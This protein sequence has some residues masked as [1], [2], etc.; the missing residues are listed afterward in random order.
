MSLYVIITLLEV[1][2]ITV[3]DQMIN[4]QAILLKDFNLSNFNGR[5]FR[6]SLRINMNIIHKAIRTD[7][8]ENCKRSYFCLINYSITRTPELLKF[9]TIS[10]ESVVFS[11]TRKHKNFKINYNIYRPAL[12][13]K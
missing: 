3:K 7:V 2:K 12:N 4:Q 9:S 8:N 11:I 1:L 13:V 6:G 5:M 10:L